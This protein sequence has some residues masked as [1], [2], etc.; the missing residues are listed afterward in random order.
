MHAH[1]ILA[2]MAD[3]AHQ[4]ALSISFVSV[5][6]TILELDANTVTKIS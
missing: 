5:L 6:G 1:P 3:L 4:I 2:I